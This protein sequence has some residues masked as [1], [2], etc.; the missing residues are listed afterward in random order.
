MTRSGTSL[1]ICEEVLGVSL[2]QRGLR[3]STI[4]RGHLGWGLLGRNRLL[5][6]TQESTIETQ[7]HLHQVSYSL[8]HRQL[9]LTASSHGK[10]LGLLQG[11]KSR[12]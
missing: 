7:V 1:V 6:G 9:V 3:K 5:T 12:S 10:G 2:V 11:H 8:L 4:D